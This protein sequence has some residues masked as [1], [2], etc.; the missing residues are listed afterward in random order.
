MPKKGL[1]MLVGELFQ[2]IA[3]FLSVNIIFYA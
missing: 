1:I 3:L 2:T